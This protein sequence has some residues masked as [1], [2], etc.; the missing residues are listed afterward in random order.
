E[1][2]PV[3]RARDA[4]PV[5]EP[6]RHEMD[7]EIFDRQQAHLPVALRRGSR[8]SVRPSPSR[9]NPRTT[10]ISARPGKVATHHSPLI[11]YSAPWRIMAPHSGAGAWMPT[12]MKARVALIRT[13]HAMRMGSCAVAPSSAV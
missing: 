8:M 1:R 10:A 11:T 12:P 7:V 3:Q 2:N 9:L 4:H 13:A 6:A 5:V